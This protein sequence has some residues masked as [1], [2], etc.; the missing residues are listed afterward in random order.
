[1]SERPT[2]CLIYTE[3]T[4]T[5]A[6]QSFRTFNYFVLSLLHGNVCPPRSM[7]SSDNAV[8]TFGS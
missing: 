8:Q 7:P 2:N 1:M 6:L 5:W 3:Y 4:V